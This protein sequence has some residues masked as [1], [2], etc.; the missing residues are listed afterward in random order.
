MPYISKEQVAQKRKELK[1][2]LPEFKFSVRNEHH[3][4]IRVKIIEGP[5]V[6]LPEGQTHADVN[7]YWI[8]EDYWDNPQVLKV[9]KT[10]YNIISHDQTESVYDLDYGSVPNFYINISIG[11]WDQPYLVKADKAAKPA[12][13]ARKDDKYPADYLPKI[14]YWAERMSQEA[15]KGNLKGVEFASKKVQ[16]FMQRQEA[17]AA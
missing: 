9:L 13:K 16:Y 2:A 10:I 3:S 8:E 15:A 11:S 4:S 14:Q 5:I 12:K 1:Q 17:L 6:M 7:D